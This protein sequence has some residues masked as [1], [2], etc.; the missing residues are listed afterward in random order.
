MGIAITIL[1]VFLIVNCLML[2][3]IILLQRGK[4]KGLAGAFGVGSMEEALGTH[5]A[6]TA[7]KITAFLGATFLLL[8]LL[9]GV[10]R[11]QHVSAVRV[12]E[13]AG[14][15]TVDPVAAPLEDPE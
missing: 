5:A 4:G 8:A 6:S 11:Q 12:P 14:E 15:T 9:I 2:V 13:P 10:L 3:G 1:T 7:Q